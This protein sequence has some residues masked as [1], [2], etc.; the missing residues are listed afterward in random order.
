MSNG[1]NV[2]AEA[3][4]PEKMFFC[5]ISIFEIEQEADTFQSLCCGAPC[6][7]EPM[8]PF[9]T[10]LPRLDN[11]RMS[12]MRI[13]AIL[14]LSSAILAPGLAAADPAQPETTTAAT[15]ATTAPSATAQSVQA[16]AAAA[17]PASKP[18]GELVI[19]RGTPENDDNRVNLDEIVCRSAPPATGTRLGGGREC[20]TVRQWNDREREDQRMLQQLQ[21]TGF[22]DQATATGGPMGK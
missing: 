22:H 11:Q 17:A 19:V 1:P 10:V 16:P 4:S 20:Y 9:F 2:Q 5:L 14:V 6:F 21:H 8:V 12:G 15:P 7:G 3:N 13:L 18:A